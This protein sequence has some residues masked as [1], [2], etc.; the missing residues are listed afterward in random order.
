[1]AFDQYSDVFLDGILDRDARLADCEAEFLKLKNLIENNKV[2]VAKQG[3]KAFGKLNILPLFCEIFSEKFIYYLEQFPM[4]RKDLYDLGV[5]GNLTEMLT[6]KFMCFDFSELIYKTYKLHSL[7]LD[8]DVWLTKNIGNTRQFRK[9]VEFL[10]FIYEITHFFSKGQLLDKK[11]D[12]HHRVHTRRPKIDWCAFCFRRVESIG[13]QRPLQ[14]IAIMHEQRFPEDKSRKTKQLLCKK[15]ESRP[16]NDS[17]Y[18]NAR[19]KAKKLSKEDRAYIDQI[20]SE[21]RLYEVLNFNKPFDNKMTTKHWEAT[22]SRWLGYLLELCP[23]AYISDIK[24]WDEFT[25]RFHLLLDNE[26]EDTQ[27]PLFIEDIYMEAKIWIELEKNHYKND[28]RRKSL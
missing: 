28:K 4:I 15:H 14:T 27:V 16:A 7:K 18:R 1:M 12:E 26:Q 3:T 25:A 21:R 5:T 23:Y 24:S 22:K 10:H 9:A 8:Q 13:E 11:D 17:I 19:T 6:D 2:T 20:H